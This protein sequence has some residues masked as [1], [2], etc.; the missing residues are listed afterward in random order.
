[1]RRGAIRVMAGLIS[2]LAGWLAGWL[3][4]GLPGAAHAEDAAGVHP[5]PVLAVLPGGPPQD[6]ALR[7]SVI[8][9]LTESGYDQ[10]ILIAPEDLAGMLDLVSVKRAPGC[11]IPLDSGRSAWTR[12]RR[13]WG[14]TS[15][16]RRGG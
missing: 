7:R 9:A 11:R 10:A 2:G 13:R 3:A 6:P 16:R 14:R 15:G 8:A 1:M 5:P 4:W 12:R